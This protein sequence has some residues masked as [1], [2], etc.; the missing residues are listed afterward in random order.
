MKNNEEIYEILNDLGLEDDEIKSVNRRNK[1]LATVLAED[2]D[3]I[4]DFFKI[5]CELDKDDIARIIIK[6]PLILNESF[7]RIDTLSKLYNSLGFSGEEYRKYIV[8]FDKAFSLNPKEL[9]DRVS[10]MIKTGEKLK[11]IREY[12]VEHANRIF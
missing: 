2:V 6:N 5:K 11:D 12:M 4:V 9:V 8:N 10:K 3:E 1:M 7:E